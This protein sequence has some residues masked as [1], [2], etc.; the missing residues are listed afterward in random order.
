MTKNAPDVSHYRQQAADNGSR[1][2]LGCRTIVLAGEPAALEH[3]SE[4]RQPIVFDQ[5][6]VA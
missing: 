1:A 6:Q 3:E 2:L 4:L 5:L